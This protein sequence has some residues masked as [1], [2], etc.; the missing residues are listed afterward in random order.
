MP[1]P[2]DHGEE[3]GNPS[4]MNNKDKDKSKKRGAEED[5]ENGKGSDWEGEEGTENEYMTGKKK[6]RKGER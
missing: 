1:R 5:T 4:C 6:T 2:T 3:P